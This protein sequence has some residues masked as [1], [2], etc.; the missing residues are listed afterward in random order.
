MTQKKIAKKPSYVS[1][2]LR[3]AENKKLTL[4]PAAKKNLIVSDFRSIV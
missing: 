1:A 4:V 2:Y 3:K